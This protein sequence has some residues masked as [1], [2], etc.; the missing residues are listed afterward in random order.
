MI[1]YK[2]SIDR[3]FASAVADKLVYKVPAGAKFTGF[4]PLVSQNPSLA[5]GTFYQLNVATTDKV[6][7]YFIE[8]MTVVVPVTVT[9]PIGYNTLLDLVGHVLIQLIK[10]LVILQLILTVHHSIMCQQTL[11]MH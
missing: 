4:K 11:Q 3:K 8:E 7:N 10:L 9:I 2:S 5:S 6:G 1:E